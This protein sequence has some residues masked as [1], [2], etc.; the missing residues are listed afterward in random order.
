MKKY[1]LPILI[2]S[3]LVSC[4][5]NIQEEDPAS[6]SGSKGDAATISDI[7]KVIEG[8]FSFKDI[9]E[10]DK[11]KAGTHFE[12]VPVVGEDKI[13]EAYTAEDSKLKKAMDDF[14]KKSAEYK[15]AKKADEKAK[16]EV[17]LLTGEEKAV[18]Q[19]KFFLNRFCAIEK[20]N[21]PA[22]KEKVE[23]FLSARKEL[24]G[25]KI[26]LSVWPIKHKLHGL[27]ADL[28]DF[29]F[30]GLKAKIKEILSAE[31]KQDLEAVSALHDQG[32]VAS[33]DVLSWHTLASSV[34]PI[35]AQKDEALKLGV[36]EITW[37]IIFTYVDVLE[38][39]IKLQQEKAE[40]D[41]VDP[42]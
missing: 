37:R 11:K 32:A 40:E 7:Q 18:E 21:T 31:L 19:Y 33:K 14:S 5:R 25:K 2:L 34:E 42:V 30:E 39:E 6:D 28:K 16:K 3:T 27:F 15:K 12:L 9:F 4:G 8:Q 22:L 1:L 24:E 35:I 29:E 20:E 10:K 17:S 26:N 36:G 23:I 13:C 41:V 38:A